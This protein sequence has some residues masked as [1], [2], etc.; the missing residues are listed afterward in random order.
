MKDWNHLFRAGIRKYLKGDCPLGVRDYHI[1][2]SNVGGENIRLAVLVDSSQVSEVTNDLRL[3]FTH[4]FVLNNK[5]YDQFLQKELFEVYPASSIRYGIYD[6]VEYFPIAGSSKLS[7]V[8]IEGLRN[9]KIDVDLIITFGC[10][11]QLLMVKSVRN[12]DPKCFFYLLETFG[13]GNRYSGIPESW[14]IPVKSSDDLSLFENTRATLFEMFKEVMDDGWWRNTAPNWMV[15]WVLCC[16]SELMEQRTNGGII[17]PEDT[18][19][20]C[21][22]KSNVIWATL[23]VSN[24][25]AFFARNCIDAMITHFAG[26]LHFKG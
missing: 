20:F 15:E 4:F 9:E 1:Q 22:R 18:I 12:V 17:N 8:L 2:L 13:T 3:F 6:P 16:T 19:T 10:Y 25:T 11:L 14:R 24:E 26:D 5:S 21:H 7:D 23:G